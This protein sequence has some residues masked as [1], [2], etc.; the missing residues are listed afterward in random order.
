MTVTSERP[1]GMSRTAWAAITVMVTAM[2]A[3]ALLTTTGTI[4]SHAGAPCHL[5]QPVYAGTSDVG[6]WTF[7][8]HT[9]QSV[10]L[11]DGDTATCTNQG[12]DVH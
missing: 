9:G 2:L 12:L 1:R 6:T 11:P 3:A 10:T 4:G 5:S 8:L 7:T